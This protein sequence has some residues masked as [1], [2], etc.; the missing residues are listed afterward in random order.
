M[1][2]EWIG[3]LLQVVA[4][5]RLSAFYGSVTLGDSVIFH[6][7]SLYNALSFRINLSDVTKRTLVTMILFI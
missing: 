2:G 5:K 3:V 1:T 4:T 7:S 6:K